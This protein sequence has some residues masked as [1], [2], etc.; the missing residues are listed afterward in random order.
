MLGTTS[1]DD[2]ISTL[3]YMDQIQE[4]NNQEIEHL[5]DMEAELAAKKTS[6]N[7]LRPRQNPSSR[8]HPTH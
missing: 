1:F 2:A 7:R 4:S 6:S 8:L 5:T 3:T